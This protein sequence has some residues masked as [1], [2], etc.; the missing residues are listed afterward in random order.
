MGPKSKG[1]G[2]YSKKQKV[3]VLEQN[4]KV[5]MSYGSK[6][7]IMTNKLAHSTNQFQ[8]RCLPLMVETMDKMKTSQLKATRI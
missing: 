8:G 6:G 3:G 5:T 4:N 7:R 1:S 2:A